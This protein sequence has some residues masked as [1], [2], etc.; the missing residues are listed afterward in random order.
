MIALLKKEINTFFSHASGAIIIISFL[1]ANSAF[2]WIISSD[3]NI[4]NSGFAQMDGLFSISP[5]LLIIF[6]PALTMRLF[7]DE[8]KEGTIERLKTLPISNTKLVLSK[9]FSGLIV[10]LM[11]IAPTLVYFY[12][13]HQLS[14][15]PGNVDSAGI[16]GSYIGLILLSA[17]FVSIGVFAS[18]TTKNQITSF[19][20]AIIICSFFY[21]GFDIIASEISNGKIELAINYLGIDYHYNSL[22]KG[23]ID[24][25]DLIYFLSLIALFIQ[26]TIHSISNNKR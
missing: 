13:V 22:S 16:F 15:T 20:I 4:I 6:I 24:S 19:L 23:V 8:Y 3:F 17:L 14:D 2:L 1:L 18:S 9:Y 21:F 12:S 11:A 10:T 5:F 26:L 25:R 7:A